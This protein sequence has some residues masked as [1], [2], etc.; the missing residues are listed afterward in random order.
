[1]INIKDFQSNLSKI[2]KKP[3]KDWIFTFN[4]YYVGYITIKKINHCKN[5]HR[6]NPLYLMFNSATRYFKKENDERYLILDSTEKYEEVLSEI[7]S[8]I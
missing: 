6:V 2:D 4:I 5:M 1:M 7:K 3:H 8:D